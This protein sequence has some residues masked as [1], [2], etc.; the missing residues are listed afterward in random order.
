MS[1][2]GGMTLS[3]LCLLFYNRYITD[4]L[5]TLKAYD[6]SLIETM[7]LTTNGVNLECEII[8]KASLRSEFILEVPVNFV[9]RT[10]AQGKKTTL[11]DGLLAIAALFRFRRM[12]GSERI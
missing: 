7:N 2:Y 1:K 12:R 11:K 9:P 5:S 10:R 8:A 6:R 4:P 3:M